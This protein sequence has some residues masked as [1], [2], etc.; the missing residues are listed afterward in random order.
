MRTIRE[1]QTICRRDF[2]GPSQEEDHQRGRG[3]S[4][5]R[6][7]RGREETIRGEDIHQRKEGHH[8]EEDHQERVRTIRE[9]RTIIGR[10]DHVEE[11]R[12]IRGRG[13]RRTFR[14]R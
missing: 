5:K 10:E 11:K 3:P 4:G 12:T 8:R 14:G 9:R 6:L 13:D 2:Q 7:I 1:R